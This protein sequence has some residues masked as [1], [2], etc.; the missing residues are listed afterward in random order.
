[1]NE[2][3]LEVPEISRDGR[4]RGEV[5]VVTG[6]GSAGTM[7]GTGAN[8][9]VLFAA[10]GAKLVLVD[11]D[12]ARAE[13]TLSAVRAL[14]GEAVVAIGDITKA[15]HCRRMI[16]TAQSAFGQIDILVNNAAIAPG[17]QANTE[18]LWDRIIDINLKGA[19]LMS[20][21]VLDPMKAQGRGS[22][23][24]ISS[25]AAL[26]AGGGIAY[27]ASKGGM[28]AMTKAQAYEYGPHGI[29]V[30]NVAP[31][32]VAIPMGLNFKGWNGA[33]TDAIRRKRARASLL[34]TEGTGW[35]VA[36]AVLFLASDEAAYITGHTLPVDGGTTAVMPIV[37]AERIL[38]D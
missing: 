14:G 9:A 1:M 15:D 6:A 4:L 8:I 23:V 30:N 12:Q 21:A 20:D 35:D 34:G 5:A 27:S 17:E 7:G 24:H 13:H 38:T 22:I 28:V 2:V 36:Y 16:E 33:G 31:G 10:K 18:E 19:K 25:I 29:R 37:M 32:H 11:I 3:R 26:A